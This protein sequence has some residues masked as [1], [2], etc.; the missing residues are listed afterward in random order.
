MHRTRKKHR[1]IVLKVNGE[2]YSVAVKEGETLLDV[3]RD[4]LHL[5]GTKKGCNLGVCGACTVLVDSQPKNSCLLLAAACEGVEITTIEGVAQGGKLHPLQRS[6]INHGAIQCG[7]CTP[8]MV[9]SSLALIRRQPEPSEEEIK[10]ALA[11]HLCRCTG[12]VRIIEAVK[13][14]KKYEKEKSTPPHPDDIDRF[15]T[16][17]KSLPRVDAAAKVTGQA[18]FTADYYFENML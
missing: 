12:Y 8:G 3:L 6:F 13:N 18:K 7:F 10:E 2:E 4:K 11:G 9:I 5:T 16:V 17:G 15:K 14:W 1:L